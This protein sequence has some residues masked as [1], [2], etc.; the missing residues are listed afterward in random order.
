M[1]R[2]AHGARTMTAATASRTAATPNRQTRNRT[3]PASGIVSR[4]TTYP[5][6]HM[7]T[8]SPGRRTR[9]VM[10]ASLRPSA[11]LASPVVGPRA[12]W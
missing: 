2:V 8:N 10:A 12:A 3:G 7:T 4:T 6:D 9:F 1:V 11:W 5:V